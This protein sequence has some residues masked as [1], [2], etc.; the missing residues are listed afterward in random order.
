MTTTHRASGALFGMAYGDALGAPTEFLSVER[1][2]QRFPPAGPTA[3][4]GD[5][6]LVT[7]DTQM[8]LAV[9]EALLDAPRPLSAASLEPPLRRRF[10]EW[11]RSPDN[12]RAPGNTCLAAC[13]R[14]EQ[15]LPWH[16][17]TAEGSKGC[18]ANMRVAP[19][20][21]LPDS[22]PGMTATTRAAIA[23]F[24]AALTHGH[25]TALAAADLTAMT[26]YYLVSGNPAADLPKWLRMY[27]AS[28]R[29]MYHADWLGTL[30]ERPASTTPEN[31]I[32]HGWEQ[33]L[34]VLDRLD[35]ALAAPDRS[36]D[37]C[38]ATG[39][40]WIAEEAFATGLLCFLL[41]PDDPVAAIRRAAVSSGDSDSIACLTGAFAGAA[42]GMDAWP[43]EW[44]S[45]IEYRERLTRLGDAWDR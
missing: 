12:T 34:T 19:V 30:W 16:Q 15:G 2:L 42:L 5:P 38:L 44:K 33:C 31:F 13:G 32:A 25:P 11:Y 26:V 4:A 37:P 17:A 6:A 22:E 24:Q 23:Q 10:L 20:G 27:A 36:A 18:G 41:F 28:Q 40:G 9:G 39:A 29:E 21:L 14:L 45:R 7:D 1:I 8:A 35:N 43:A 3:P